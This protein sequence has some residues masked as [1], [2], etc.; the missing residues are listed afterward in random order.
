MPIRSQALFAFNNG[1]HKALAC[2]GTYPYDLQ[3]SAR[4]EHAPV[5]LHG[6]DQC[7]QLDSVYA[8]L[9]TNST[10]KGYGR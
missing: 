10:R 9:L 6:Y 7:S 8:P 4:G 2:I 1:A 5:V 3:D